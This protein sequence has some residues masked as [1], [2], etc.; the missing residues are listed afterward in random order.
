MAQCFNGLQASRSPGRGEPGQQADQQRTSANQRD[1]ARVNDCGKL[2][3]VVD[4]GREQLESSE[5][6]HEFE[7]L[8]PVP[9]CQHAKTEARYYS[10]NSDNQALAEKEP[11]HLRPRGAESFEHPYLA[12]FL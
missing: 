3:E 11:Q 12:C 1:V 9:H 2:C 6:A 8:V 5:P 4:I 7:K 10:D